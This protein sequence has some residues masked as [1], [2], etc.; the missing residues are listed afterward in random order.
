MILIEKYSSF[1]MSP[2]CRS[3][4]RRFAASAAVW[5][6]LV[7]A[8]WPTLRHRR[9]GGRASERS[10]LL[11]AEWLPP[12]HVQAGSYR[13]TSFLQYA[14][15]NGWRVTAI[16]AELV[17]PPDRAALE[18]AS[19]IPKDCSIIR[20]PAPSVQAIR[21]VIPSLDGRIEIA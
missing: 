9:N 7:R 10:L 16:T 5:A 3:L 4:L 19:R 11:L 12:G 21:R 20:V 8:E 1:L 17:K 15:E 6:H 2:F 13:P 18:L 14:R